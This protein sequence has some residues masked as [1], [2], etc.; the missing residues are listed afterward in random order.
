M[1]WFMDLPGIVQGVIIGLVVSSVVWLPQALW[2]AAGTIVD[3]FHR[4]PTAAELHQAGRDY[5]HG[6]DEGVGHD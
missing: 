6:F 4:P 5:M 1:D 2:L 3:A